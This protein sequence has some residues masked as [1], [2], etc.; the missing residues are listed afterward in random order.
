MYGCFRPFTGPASLKPAAAAWWPA[1]GR[2]E[3]PAL[4]RAG[5]IEAPPPPAAAPPPRS[6]F[7][8]FTGPASL[9]HLLPHDLH[10]AVPGFRP[11]TGPASLKR[12]VGFIDADVIGFPA[13]HRAGLIE[14]SLPFAPGAVMAPVS[15]P[16]QGRPH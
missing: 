8:P 11:F 3:F 2:L 6:G 7:R 12:A 15:G 1:T 10:P 9:K 13:L 16:S 5:L 14:A 4:H